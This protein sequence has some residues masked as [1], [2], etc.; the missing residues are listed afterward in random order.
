[1]RRALLAA[2]LA[3]S[4]GGG[5]SPS[6]ESIAPPADAGA[7][8]PGPAAPF[9]VLNGCQQS[10]Y[11]DA[12]KPAVQFGM[13]FYKPRCLIVPPATSVLFEGDFN[14]HPLQPGPAPGVRNDGPGSEANPIPPT[15]KGTS[16]SFTF[17]HR[18]LFP[19]YCRSHDSAMN[20]V[21]WVR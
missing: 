3:I 16:A 18:G 14:M 4:C 7:P 12:P 20:G 5:N 8:D 2:V 9:V 19:Y 1:V 17:S 21:V 13:V 10:D 11:T 15:L 6:H